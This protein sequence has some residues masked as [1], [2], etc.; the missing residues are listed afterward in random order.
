MLISNRKLQQSLEVGLCSKE[1]ARSSA[2]TSNALAHPLFSISLFATLFIFT[3]GH[4][5][6]LH[7][8]WETLE[9]FSDEPIT[10][11][12]EIYS[13]VELKNREFFRAINDPGL[14]ADLDQQYQAIQVLLEQGNAFSLV[15][16][17]RYVE[18]ARILR[19]A[20]RLE[21]AVDVLMKALHIQ[22]ANYGL[23]DERHR[24]LLKMMFEFNFEQNNVEES[25]E[26]LRRL[27]LID[28]QIGSEDNEL[29]YDMLVRMG[30]YYID[31]HLQVPVG[32]ESSVLLIDNAIGYFRVA[33][34]KSDQT[35]LSEQLLPYGEYV[36]AAYLQSKALEKNQSA[37]FT[38]LGRSSTAFEQD[39]YQVSISTRRAYANS[40]SVLNQF[41]R[42]A[43]TEEL[44]DR[45][46][47]ALLALGDLNML[48][49]RRSAAE[50]YYLE[51]WEASRDLPEN[52]AMR[53]VF[54][55]L[56]KLPS[57]PFSQPW[58]RKINEDRIMVSVP[59]SLN[60]SQTG[61]VQKVM[62]QFE[63][64]PYSSSIINRAKRT[65]RNHVF[66]P[67]VI[68]GDIANVVGED[69]VIELLVKK[70]QLET[71][72]VKTETPS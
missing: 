61:K 23:F 1:S 15:L 62:N 59:V 58:E 71:K 26:N 41:L 18:Y 25:E 28:R 33:I 56:I 4:S 17:E 3:F 24:F 19:E 42:S 67:R 57:F 48:Y 27:M 34:A 38:R 50:R 55:D 64:L 66:R 21:E 31:Q 16:G 22:K 9:D 49:S 40:N 29:T 72:A 43:Q 13:R 7:A 45:E 51:A 54:N 8:Q 2:S 46:V 30:H 10:I 6:S 32:S 53:S 12:K 52:H 65:V 11:E 39:R 63:E 44:K 36:F 47:Q 60:I 35:E 5:S 70:K 14:M 20:G 68:D 37:D 69:Y